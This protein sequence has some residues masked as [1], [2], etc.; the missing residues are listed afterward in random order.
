MY[1]NVA[2]S[3]VIPCSSQYTK[4]E[5]SSTPS[6]KTYIRMHERQNENLVVFLLALAQLQRNYLLYLPT[7]SLP[8]HSLNHIICYGKKY[9]IQTDWNGLCDENRP[10]PTFIH[11]VHTY[12]I[13][14]F[15][16]S[17]KMSGLAYIYRKSHVL[18]CENSATYVVVKKITCF[19]YSSQNSCLSFASCY[20]HDHYNSKSRENM[21]R[22]S[23]LHISEKICVQPVYKK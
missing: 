20:V 9:G 18:I 1:T 10:P 11:T 4:M 22:I 19:Y 2:M 5:L 3:T 8:L 16:S 23:L 13:A 21:S 6:C 12:T 17:G 15:H 7:C 14:N